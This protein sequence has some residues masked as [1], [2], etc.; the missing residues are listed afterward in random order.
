[1]S[2][3]CR[4]DKIKQ[5]G[6][7]RPASSGPISSSC[8]YLIII[9]KVKRVHIIHMVPL[10][11]C[12]PRQFDCADPTSARTGFSWD[13]FPASAHADG[14]LDADARISRYMRNSLIILLIKSQLAGSRVNLF[15][16][17]EVTPLT[18]ANVKNAHWLTALRLTWLAALRHMGLDVDL[19]D[20]W[21]ASCKL[22]DPGTAAGH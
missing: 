19:C 16:H 2:E 8:D 10:C 20:S 21:C 14:S 9:I 15:L 22:R 12:S 5:S 11:F 17:A 6:W 7:L 3:L 1:M 13:R 4:A 18:A